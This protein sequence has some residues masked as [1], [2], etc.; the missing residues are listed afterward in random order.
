MQYEYVLTIDRTALLNCRSKGDKLSLYY[1]LETVIS[2][3]RKVSCLIA[4][5]QVI[6]P[7]EHSIPL[8]K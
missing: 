2:A 4:L 6:V 1:G 7:P 8:L 3:F 5:W